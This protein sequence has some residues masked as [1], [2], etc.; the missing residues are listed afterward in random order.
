MPSKDVVIPNPFSYQRSRNYT[1]SDP[2]TDE[3]ESKGES[4]MA[5]EFN[6]EH[7]GKVLVVRMSGKL[8]KED[9]ELFVPEFDRLA[10]EFGEVRVLVEMIDFQGWE[11]GALWE[12]LKLDVKHFSDIERLALVGEKKWEK[13]MSVFCKPFTTAEVRY[14]DRSEATQAREWIESG[15]KA[16]V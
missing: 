6:E 2:R 7:G 11:V 1:L 13:G 9:Y 4:S 16:A 12:D 15:L 10:D 8:A 5:V 3:A 14:F